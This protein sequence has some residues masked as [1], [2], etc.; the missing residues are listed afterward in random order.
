MT[1]TY[2]ELELRL[3]SNEGQILKVQKQICDQLLG[4]FGSIGYLGMPMV[5]IESDAK[6]KVWKW[7]TAQYGL[8]VEFSNPIYRDSVEVRGKPVELGREKGELIKFPVT[9]KSG[10]PI[11]KHI[12]KEVTI[13]TNAQ[14]VESNTFG[15]A[16]DI[17]FEGGVS[18]Q[19]SNWG[20]TALV[21]TNANLNG[22]FL[23]SWV[24]DK[25]NQAKRLISDTLE[26][27]PY[28]QYSITIS[29]DRLKL[30]QKLNIIGVLDFNI[31]ITTPDWKDKAAP[32]F[33]CE[34]QRL[35]AGA[36]IKADDIRSLARKLL[37]MS[38]DLYLNADHKNEARKTQQLLDNVAALIND[39]LRE[40]ETNVVLSYNDA[41]DSVLTVEK[42][43]IW[44]KDGNGEYI[45]RKA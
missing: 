15:F 34:I 19:P 28:S 13:S 11:S 10:S 3:L 40:V 5:N 1:V 18:G 30:E 41:S 45:L 32:G 26:L 42:D 24:S 12:S 44:A 16:L 21:K 14:V 31:K 22:S 25:G 38:G 23:R 37:G 20:A 43:G 39:K 4:C 29:V 27:E 6:Q 9:N 35:K 36:T 2:Q 8:A 33:N 7:A 17:G